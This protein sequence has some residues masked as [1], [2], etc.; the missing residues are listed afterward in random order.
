MS[1]ATT[2]PLTAEEF[3][4]LDFPQD[5]NWELHDGAVAEEPFPP[6]V[7]RLIQMRV[8]ALLGP[9]FRRAQVV[10]E[11]PF[12][13]GG[14]D[15]RSAD[16]A[17][18]SEHRAEVALQKGILTDAPEMVVEVLSPLKGYLELKRYRRLCLNHGTALFL[19]ID[20]EDNTVEVFTQC[21]KVATYA[22]EESL[23]VVLLDVSSA[24][25]VAQIFQGITL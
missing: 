1:A 11:C 2:Q 16:V 6:L 22:V 14:R 12:Q 24:I 5:M 9:L 23:P 21:G 7:N 15:K 4:R 18:V 8:V 20:P 3:D 17:V 13:I 25:P 19:V 10:M